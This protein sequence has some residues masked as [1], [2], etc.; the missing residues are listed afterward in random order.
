MAIF[1]NGS[2]GT[3]EST[4]YARGRKNYNTFELNGENGSVFFN[5]EDPQYLEYF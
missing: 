5:L 4:R 3:F 1:Q 2:V